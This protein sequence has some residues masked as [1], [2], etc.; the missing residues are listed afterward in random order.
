MTK[1]DALPVEGPQEL[2]RRFLKTNACI[3]YDGSIPCIKPVSG[4]DCFVAAQAIAEIDRLGRALSEAHALRDAAMQANARLEPYVPFAKHMGAP[5]PVRKQTEDLPE[6]YKAGDPRGQSQLAGQ[7]N[8]LH[9]K[10]G[11]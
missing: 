10:E 8:V 1:P 3:G 7:S 9:P 5:S 6:G 4:C 11:S 2:L